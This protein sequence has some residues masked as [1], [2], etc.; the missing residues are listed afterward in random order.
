VGRLQWRRDANNQVRAT[1]RR[2]TARWKSGRGK[3]GSPIFC[4]N[5][6]QKRLLLTGAAVFFVPDKNIFSVRLA[7]SKALLTFVVY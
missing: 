2:V 5:H 6:C 4:G 3:P 7:I 1:H